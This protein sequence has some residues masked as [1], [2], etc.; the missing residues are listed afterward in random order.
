MYLN[1]SYRLFKLC[2]CIFSIGKIYVLKFELLLSI[3]TGQSPSNRIFS[4]SKIRQQYLSNGSLN[5]SFYIAFFSLEYQLSLICNIFIPIK[6][7]VVVLCVIIFCF[8]IFFFYGILYVKKL[9]SNIIIHF[10]RNWV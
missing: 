5:V 10:C 6:I 4:C 9:F 2:V 7:C 1:F 3:I 8:L